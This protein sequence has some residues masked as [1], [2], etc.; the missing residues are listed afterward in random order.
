MR[1]AVTEH[2]AHGRKQGGYERG[3]V[4]YQCWPARSHNLL[5]YLSLL[6]VPA[7]SPLRL[8]QQ[9]AGLVKLIPECRTSGGGIQ[10]PQKTDELH[11]R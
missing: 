8:E 2:L 9:L 10:M 7:P 11:Q 5:G 3:Q 1:N 4:R 6:L